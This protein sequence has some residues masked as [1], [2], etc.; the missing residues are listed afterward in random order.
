VVFSRYSTNK[1]D[2]HYITEIWLKVALNTITTHRIMAT[3]IPVLLEAKIY[4]CK[5]LRK[6]IL[7]V[8][9]YIL[10][11]CLI[12]LQ[13]YYIILV[14]TFGEIHH[15]VPLYKDYQTFIGLGYLEK[16]KM[17]QQLEP[18]SWRGVLYTILCD[19]V[20][21]TCSRSVVFSR[22]STNKIDCQDIT[23]IY[24]W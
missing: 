12:H 18:C 13:F 16:I 10:T 14:Q 15:T 24:Q 19:K 23:E 3:L 1:I 20:C 5:M 7:V 17:C 11:G 2:C 22:Y 6:K 9:L 21:L 4:I 8:T